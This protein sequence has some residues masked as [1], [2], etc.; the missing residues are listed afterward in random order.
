ML[1]CGAQALAA[2]AQARTDVAALIARFQAKE[3]AVTFKYTSYWN[4]T[5]GKGK[6]KREETC[7]NYGEAL[8]LIEKIE[9]GKLPQVK[10][11]GSNTYAPVCDVC[12]HKSP[13]HKTLDGRTVCVS[14][15]P[16]IEARLAAEQAAIAQALAAQGVLV[17]LEQAP[18]WAADL[19][20]SKHRSDWREQIL[21]ARGGWVEG[22][23]VDREIQAITPEQRREALRT[24]VEELAWEQRQTATARHLASATAVAAPSTTPECGAE[25]SVPARRS[26]AKILD[27]L[28]VIEERWAGGGMGGADGD[29]LEALAEDLEAQIGELDAEVYDS[30]AKQITGLLRRLIEQGVPS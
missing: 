15:A 3:W 5:T 16:P 25:T 2:A 21:G 7:P 8:K 27:E 11:G 14:C 20:L 12:R 22:D 6:A 24:I 4:A 9:K 10:E 19:L 29:T 17:W 30:T 26:I 18:A 23:V 1:V 28:S 13:E